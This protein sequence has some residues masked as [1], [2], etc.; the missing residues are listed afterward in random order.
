MEDRILNKE[1]QI[2]LIQGDISPSI[3]QRRAR[4]TSLAMRHTCQLGLQGNRKNHKGFNFLQCNRYRSYTKLLVED[5]IRPGLVCSVQIWVKDKA[6]I[7][8]PEVANHKG[9]HHHHRHHNPH[10]HHYNICLAPPPGDYYIYLWSEW[11]KGFNPSDK[12]WV[13]S[14][15]CDPEDLIPVMKMSHIHQLRYRGFNPSDLLMP[16]TG[17]FSNPSDFL[18]CRQKPKKN[19]SH[20]FLR[21]FTMTLRFSWDQKNSSWR[22]VV[23]VYNVYI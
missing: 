17:N 21:M 22:A 7:F 20:I 8:L 5:G 23:N 1:E 18:D 16:T 2:W 6:C 12:N 13:K 14:T 9:P 3:V 15:N 19:H 4:Y 11:S 10:H